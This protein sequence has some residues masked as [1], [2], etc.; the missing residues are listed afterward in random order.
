MIIQSL[1]SFIV[2][3]PILI[4]QNSFCI[5]SDDSVTHCLYLGFSVG[6]LKFSQVQNRQVDQIESINT[7][8]EKKERKDLF[9]VLKTE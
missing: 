3:L 9:I 2:G 5:T 7:A 6:A 1:T 8:I 4:S